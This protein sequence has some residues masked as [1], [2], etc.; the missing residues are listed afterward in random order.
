V[1]LDDLFALRLLVE[2]QVEVDVH[3]RLWHAHAAHGT[4]DC[5]VLC[6]HAT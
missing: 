3:L 2:A 4:G 1:G 5:V 6:V